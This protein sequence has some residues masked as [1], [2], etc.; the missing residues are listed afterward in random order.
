[1]VSGR[2]VKAPRIAAAPS[3]MAALGRRVRWRCYA[4]TF[5][6]N[7]RR[8]SWRRQTCP[9]TSRPVMLRLGMMTRRRCQVVGLAG[10][11]FNPSF[12][13]L[14]AV[15]LIDGMMPPLAQ[16]AAA[17]AARSGHLGPLIG[18]HDRRPRAT[19]R[20]KAVLRITFPDPRD[21]G[22]IANRPATV[23][24]QIRL[25]G[26][27]NNYWPSLRHFCPP[28]FTTTHER[29]PCR[30]PRRNGRHAALCN[31]TQLKRRDSVSSGR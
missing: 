22:I 21:T 7:Q 31:P 15:K 30:I 4:I 28:C 27:R 24:D 26:P 10:R 3:V 9:R 14:M 12:R 17:G 5:L 20:N 6:Y 18:S 19:A 29:P 13:M 16:S 23:V 1:M 11:G 25:F 8:P 2:W